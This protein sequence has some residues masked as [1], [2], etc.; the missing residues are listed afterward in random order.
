[1]SYTHG[2]KWT[3][4]KVEK[5]IR[6]VMEAL[7]IDRMPSQSETVLV[8]KNYALANKIRRSGGFEYWANK[9]NLR[10][11]S[12]ETKF[13]T[14]FEKIIKRL[15]E[16]K[17]YKVEEM[18]H[19]HPYDLLVNDNVKIDVKV[20]KPYSSQETGTFH[21]FNLE[22]KHPTCDIYVAVLLTKLN[23]KDRVLV[24]PSKYLKI[25]QL[26]VGKNSKYNR[27]IDKW[28]YVKLYDELYRNIV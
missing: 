18:P 3:E 7:V 12:S 4:Q 6:K 21:T 19:R 9:M 26:S 10:I 23:Q 13:G 8:T 16:Q 24:I 15:L 14:R 2:I 11:K 17:G 5:E 27:F 20:A 25:T 28:E 22:K 1:M